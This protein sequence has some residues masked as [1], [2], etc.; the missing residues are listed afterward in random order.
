MCK[1]NQKEVLQNEN[2]KGDMEN[3]INELGVDSII[4]ERRK[5]D[6]HRS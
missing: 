3:Q 5:V 6:Q 4:V 2:L 1:N